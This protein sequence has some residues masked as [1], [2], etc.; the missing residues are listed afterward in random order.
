MPSPGSPSSAPLEPTTAR[1]VAQWSTAIA[2]ANA[3]GDY[4]KAID[5]ATQALAEHPGSMPLAYQRLLGFARVGAARRAEA[6][7]GRLESEGELRSIADRRLRIDFLAL[8]GRLLKDRAMSASDKA[9]RRD[10]A[11]QAARAYANAFELL[12]GCFLAVNAATLWRIAGEPDKAAAFARQALDCAAAETDPY[13]RCASEGEAWIHL[14]DPGQAVRALQAAAVAAAGR[15]DAIA[16]TRRQLDWLARATGAGGDALAA[17]PA[18]RVLHWVADPGA[19]RLAPPA[20]I[21]PGGAGLVAF[22]ALLSHADVAIAEALSR[23]GAELNLTF[24]CAAD[25]CREFLTSLGGQGIAARFDTLVGVA[26]NVTVVTPEGDPAESTLVELAIEQARGQAL[27]RA[28][29]LVTEAEGLYWPNGRAEAR[30]L[31]ADSLELRGLIARWP[32]LGGGAPIWSRRSARALVFGDIKGFSTIAESQHPAFFQTILGGFADALAPLAG[33]VEYAE[34]A[35]DGIY[36]VL[37][38][39]VAAVI[40]CHALQR[41][42]DPERLAAAGLSRELG[43]R[44]SAHVGPVFQGLDRVT[45]RE[46]FFGKEVVRTA[47]IEPVT[48]MGET[49]VTE[50]FAAT[51]AFVAGDRYACEYVGRQA[52]AKGFG[53]CRMYSLREVTR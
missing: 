52:M 37:S 34:T 40:A 11:A 23:E 13:W 31:G 17:M 22:G 26:R 5:V 14:G 44:L 6:E 30:A 20:A 15:L 3:G 25:V 53:E 29:G 41:S 27:I 28:A 10:L 50:Q 39:V 47:R 49:Y 1:S 12:G 24:P 46:K 33:K 8:R 51:L 4:L 19:E 7:L 2:A 45:G 21:S 18:P 16:S 9:S 35:G 36:L 38:D 42:V 32:S 48:P 43:L